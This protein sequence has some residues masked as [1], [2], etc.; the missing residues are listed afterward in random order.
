MKK[1]KFTPEQISKIL[2]EFEA[3]KS[4]A[5]ISREHGVSQAAFYKWRQ[6]YAGKC[7]SCLFRYFH[8]L[9]SRHWRKLANYH[10]P[11]F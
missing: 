5:E 4:A 8:Y 1:N 7:L 9:F 11:L 2:K 3:G 10:I 6:R